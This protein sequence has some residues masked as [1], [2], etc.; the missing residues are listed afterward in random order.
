MQ[1]APQMEKR[2]GRHKYQRLLT[3]WLGALLA[4]CLSYCNAS[5]ISQSVALTWNPSSSTNITGYN[6]YYGGANGYYTNMVSVGNLTNLTVSGLL[7]GDTYYFTV[8]AVNG[9]GFQSGYSS[10]TSYT[11]LQITNSPFLNITNVV[12]GMQVSNAA[13]TVMG[14]ATDTVAVASV[15][16]SLDSAPFTPAT[17][18]GTLWSAALTLTTGTNT[19]SAYAVD[20]SGNIS[21]TD[22]VNIVYVPN[23]TLTVQT[24]GQGSVSPNYNGS[25]LQ[26][27][28]VYTMTA[29]PANGFMFTNWTGGT[30]GTF[31]LYTTG[32]T[33]TFTMISNLV[34]RANFVD[35]NKPWLSIT[36]ITPGM[37]VSS[38]AFTVMGQDTDNVAVA[39][40]YYS[41]DSAPYAAANT[42][43]LNWNAALTLITGTNTISAY[44]VDTSGNI[45]TTDTVNI[46]YAPNVTL[47]VQTVGQGSVSPNYNGSLLQ[48]GNV[49]TMTAIPANGFM[50]ANWTGGT[51][52]PLAYYT[53]NPTVQFTMLANLTMQAN[54]VE[55]NKPWLSITNVNPGMLWSNASFTV[56]GLA[57][58]NVAVASVYYSLNSASFASA[59]TNGIIWSAALTLNPG[60][61]T[62][63]AYAVDTSGNISMTDTVNLVY[64]QSATL[65]VQTNGGVSVSPDYNGSLL[66][67][68]KVYS[69]TATT[70]NG[71]IFTNWTGKANG[72]F[73]FYTNTST[74]TF[75]MEPNLVL[76]AN[77]AETAKPTVNV[78]NLSSGQQVSNSTFIVMG[79]ASDAWLISNVWYQVNGT[80][81]KTATSPDA[82]TNW[83]AVSVTNLT[84]GTNVFQV[85]AQNLG[86]QVSA[87]NSLSFQYVVNANL[88][89][90]MSGLG[91][92][93]PDYSN[94]VLHLGQNYSLNASYANGF[95]FT[96]WIVSTNFIGGVVSNNPTLLFTMATN[97]TL[98]ANF[99]ETARPTLTISSPP[100]GTHVTNALSTVIGTAS[101]P[102]K[103]AMVWYRLNNGA[104]NG[105]TS[106]NSYTNWISSLELTAGTN[107]FSAY[108][109]NLG[110]N[111]STTNSVT[112]ISS[113][114]FQMQSSFATSPSV[115]TGLSLNLNMSP[116]LSGRILVST[117]M[118]NWTVLTNFTTGTSPTISIYDPNAT[119]SQ[120]FYR[121]V[122]P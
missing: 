105:A 16:Y 52:L 59:T 63:S 101:D 67:I 99:A 76:A 44:A 100:S 77:L 120:R 55:T 21:T 102:W 119:N 66:Q 11:L 60:T 30:F 93:N 29:T 84:A 64:I 41:L 95:M 24:V 104:W 109:M 26:L 2:F 53:N 75:M 62:I 74:V 106:T 22:T 73:V 56:A 49:Y 5:Q 111:Y 112:L 65:T 38:A 23:V 113:N 47:I 6:V 32:P 37:Q 103:V 108:A 70:V 72:T 51:S 98:Q 31:N 39:H 18:N 15:Y 107:T 117:D 25:L 14:L 50:F 110:G 87:T 33:V 43:G 82:N 78:T 8:T 71:F 34:M 28:K 1:P 92:I 40:V 3:F 20:S 61:N 17:T 10:Q 9:S 115:N 69:M 19:I 36:N 90:Q 13:F 58:D 54:F 118:I 7:A 122:S 97:L 89:I 88:V 57:T 96:N 68:G 116:N 12:S 121:A 86:G 91:T 35:T 81:W 85:Y 114:T 46:V 27:G 79:N 45:S 80:G 48:L 83:A 94:A 4:C 42:N